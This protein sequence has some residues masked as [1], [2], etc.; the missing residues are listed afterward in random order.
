M[1]TPSCRKTEEYKDKS[2]T[3]DTIHVTMEWSLGLKPTI[4][5]D[6]EDRE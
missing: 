6:L 4:P 3:V 5:L 1:R 2:F